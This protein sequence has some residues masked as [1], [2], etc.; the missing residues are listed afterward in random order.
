M[1][2]MNLQFGGRPVPW[3]GLGA[4]DAI[5]PGIAALQAAVA[6]Y[7][8][9]GITNPSG[10]V[11]GLQAAGNAA[12]GAVGPAID[13]MSGGSPDIMKMT[14]W[15][16][17]QNGKLAAVN[18]SGS[19]TQADVDAAKAIIGQMITFYQQASKLA[20]SLPTSA[21]SIPVSGGGR[22]SQVPA[23]AP[24]VDSTVPVPSPWPTLLAIGGAVV[25]VV[26]GVAVAVA[27]SRAA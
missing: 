18:S 5:G 16:W 23:T 11:A 25:V 26:G 1:T 24:P 2:G 15:A 10:A 27:R 20:A 4:P 3:F 21:S 9:P 14:Q 22:P 6:Q 12:V 17:Q 19:A 13:A 8:G 7:G